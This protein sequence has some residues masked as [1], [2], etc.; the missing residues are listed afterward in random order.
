MKRRSWE[1]WERELRRRRDVLFKEVADT[2]DDLRFLAEDRESEIEERGQSERAAR[3]LAALDVRGKR[4]IE[5]IDGALR[6]IRD[7]TYG[8][9][10]ECGDNIALPRLQ[11]LPA[12]SFCIDCARERE[13]SAAVP[14]GEEGATQPRELPSEIS[15]MRDSEAEAA[16]W[17]MVRNDGGIDTEELRLV[18]RHGIVYLNGAVPSENEHRRLVKLIA[19]VAGIQEITDRLLVNELLWE[20]PERS[21]ATVVASEEQAEVEP[22]ATEDIVRSEEEGLEYVPPIAP[23]EEER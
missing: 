1:T 22:A 12:T 10:V 3:L 16:L 14:V 23:P 7:G 20:R 4:E 19:D 13:E 11:A 21:E 2:E 5:E 17:E 15:L 18:Y 6:R 8:V 9:C